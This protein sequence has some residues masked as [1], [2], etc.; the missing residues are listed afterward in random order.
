ME[1]KITLRYCSGSKAGTSGEFPVKDFR[2]I[3]IGRDPDCEVVY[4]QDKDDLVSRMHSKIRVEAGD[5]PSCFLSDAA[6]RNGTF[7]NRQKVAGEVKLNPGDM[8][9]LG[10]GGPELEFD[11]LP[12]PA[13]PTRLAAQVPET[14]TV[15]RPAPTREATVGDAGAKPPERTV[16]GKETV[17]R[18]IMEGQKKTP[19][20]FVWVAAGLVGLLVLV[21]ALLAIPAVRR[22][23]GLGGNGLAPAEVARLAGESVVYF[24]V[25]WKLVDQETGLPLHQ[26]MIPNKV[27]VAAPPTPPAPPNAPTAGGNPPTPAA[28]AAPGEQPGD[29][30]AGDSQSHRQH[31]GRGQSQ[32]DVQPQPVP[33]PQPAQEQELAPGGPDQLPAFVVVGG[34]IEPLLTTVPQGPV[35]GYTASGSGFVVST[36]GFIL[37]NRHVAAPW[38]TRYDEFN[39]PA[40][41]VLQSDDQGHIKATPIGRSSFPAWVPFKAKVKLANGRL[42]LDQPLVPQLAPLQAEGRGERLD[43]TFPRNRE[44]V[45]AKLIRVSDSVDVALVKIDLPRPLKKLELNDNYN[46]IAQGDAISILGYPAVSPEMTGMV[47]SKEALVPAIE[48]RSI[49]DPTLSVGNIGRILR[50]KVGLSEAVVSSFGDT[51]QLTV[52]STGAGNSGGPVFDEQGRVIGLFTYSITADARITLAVPIRYGIELMG[53]KPVM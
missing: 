19:A 12:R 9:Q 27:Q 29:V 13:K 45:G 1:P 41:V 31:A 50:G 14:V 11:L 28:P 51:Y 35:I 44:R 48:S 43:V 23:I 5:P 8:I 40:G 46:T 42:D 25:S 16:V 7:V 24:E 52:N 3:S 22:S 21:A 30:P 53:T 17:E 20:G 39:S 18:M 15:K 10:A 36:D 6:S 47:A 2:M 38:N 33:Q 4:D 26:V 37:T 49:P 32:A 34:A